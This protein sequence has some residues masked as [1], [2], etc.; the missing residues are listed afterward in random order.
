MTLPEFELDFEYQELRGS[1]KE[2]GGVWRYKLFED[3]SIIIPHLAGH[4]RSIS[5]R[6][7]KR[8]EWARIDGQVLTIR[9][10]YVWNGCSPTRYFPI[11]G[12]IGTPT[13]PSVRL[14]SL[15]HDAMFQFVNVADWP[16]PYKTCNDLFFDIMRASGF[17]WTCIYHGA[18]HRFGKRFA[19]E[20]PSRGE[21]S[22]VL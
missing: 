10:G 21:H 18:V 3:I 7:A 11:I 2:S 15:V 5:F 14:A 16:I 4:T 12:W 19:G 1:S 8:R 13:P 22:V 20:F 17:R 6:D 9:E